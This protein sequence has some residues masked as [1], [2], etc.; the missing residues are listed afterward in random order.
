MATAGARVGVW[1]IATASLVLVGA[2]AGADEPPR[3]RGTP[4]SEV[5]V[6][7]TYEFRPRAWDADGDLLR[8]RV[9]NKPAWASFDSTTGALSGRPEPGDVGTYR[10]VT[11]RVRDGTSYRTLL[12][13]SITVEARLRKSSYGHYF[14]TRYADGPEDAALIC[15]QPGVQGVV[16]RRT[17]KE[18]EPAPGVYDFSSFDAALTAMAGSHNPECQLWLLVEFK[19]FNS[20]P[21]RNPCPER[22]AGQYSA[23]N[24]DGDGASTCFMWE[25]AVLDAYVTMMRAAAARYDANPR[26]EGLILQESA[27]GFRGE[28]SQDVAD[29]GTYTATAW[30][31]ALVTL[32]TECGAAFS[33]SRCVAF[34]NFI[35]GGQQYLHE[36]SEAIAAIP[37]RR[38]C[39]SGPDVL[40]DDASLYDGDAAVYEV[41]ARHDG[42]RSNSVQNA[43]FEV[44]A[45][46]LDCILR[47]AIGGAFGDFD[48][49][50][51]RTSGLCV[52]SYLFWNHRVTRSK[53]GL[54]WTDAL[55][56]IAA[57][58]YGRAWQEQCLGGGEAP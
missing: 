13:F 48:Q 53:T 51:P 19:S 22:L 25:P 29:G 20:S 47:F 41:L 42:C 38:G 17:W 50:S 15:D 8:F 35:R 23:Q 37:D 2:R 18:V 33:R 55:P 3:I 54:D 27:L 32:I 6:G 44:P 12:P 34:L 9:R 57:N 14:A 58:P 36:V 52:N 45:C 26:V 1:A 46:G 28:Y 10:D 30:R 21:V 7:T 11:I 31:D 49:G 56:V 4:P 40:P 5:T 16:W 43:S 39:M 24:A